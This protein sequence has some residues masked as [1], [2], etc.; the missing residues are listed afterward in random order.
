MKPAAR[1]KQDQG[2]ERLSSLD[3]WTDPGAEAFLLRI[4][5]KSLTLL[6]AGVVPA[7]VLMAT[8][9]ALA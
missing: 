3:S 6:A 5:L 1:T 7:G 8:W 4:L 2:P 9:C